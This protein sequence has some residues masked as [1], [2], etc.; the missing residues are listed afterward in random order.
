MEWLEFKRMSQQVEHQLAEQAARLSE[1]THEATLPA[2]AG[3]REEQTRQ[4]GVLL[5]GYAA[6]NPWGHPPSEC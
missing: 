6:T 4:L 5:R 1:M 2:T 3:D